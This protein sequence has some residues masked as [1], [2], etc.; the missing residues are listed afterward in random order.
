M[1][2]RY[3]SEGAEKRLKGKTG[4]AI[5]RALKRA[6]ITD[7]VKVGTKPGKPSVVDCVGLSSEACARL[8]ALLGKE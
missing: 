3:A 2:S 7:A 5:E 1:G 6:G 4:T 8:I